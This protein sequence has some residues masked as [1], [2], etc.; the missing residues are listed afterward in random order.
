LAGW[1]FLSDGF[2]VNVA[3]GYCVAAPL[4]GSAGLLHIWVPMDDT[5]S[6][7]WTVMWRT[8]RPMT[9]TEVADMVE[10]PV[11]HVATYDPAGGGLRGNHQNRFFQD[12]MWGG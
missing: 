1:G 12:R 10:G 9:R 7:V 5:H 4:D 11:P 2:A 8:Q 6:H 3:H